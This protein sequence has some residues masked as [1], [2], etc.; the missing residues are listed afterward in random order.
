V[1]R[2]HRWMHNALVEQR[3]HALEM[4]TVAGNRRT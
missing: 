2:E 1:A 3:Q 4:R